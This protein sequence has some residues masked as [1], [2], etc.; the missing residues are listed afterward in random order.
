[1]NASEIERLLDKYY[2]G[3]TT[4]EEELLLKEF[5]QGENIPSHLKIHADQFLYFNKAVNEE[6]MDPLFEQKFFE[7]VG[8]VSLLML[9]TNRR[10]FYYLSGIA[11]GILLLFGVIFSVRDFINDDKRIADSGNMDAEMAFATTC[12]VLSVVSVNFNK[13][14]DKIQYL[15]QFEKAMFKTQLLSKFYQYENLI[16]NPDPLTGRSIK[17]DKQ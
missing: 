8:D 10:R 12:D 11:A 4:L 7:K 6:I 3:L 15:G 13:G 9:K 2:D 16:I 5:F 1:M 14:M 17:S